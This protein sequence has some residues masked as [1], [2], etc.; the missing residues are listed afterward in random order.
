MEDYTMKHVLNFKWPITALMIIAAIV[1]FIMC[2]N[3]PQV[4]AKKGDVQLADNMRNDQAR[5]CLEEHNQDIEM[6]A[7]VLEF[8]SA[9]SEHQEEIEPY[10]EELEG[11]DYTDNVINPFTFN[12]DMQ[13]KFINE[14][15]GV[16]MIHLEY[17]GKA[18]YI[19]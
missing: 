8:D 11:L 15:S 17:S 12:D 7:A 16:I 10:L 19:M 3:V 13:E 9:P 1:S 18:A 5:Q 6:M 4:A 2:P 14:D